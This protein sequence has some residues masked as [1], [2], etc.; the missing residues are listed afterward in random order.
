MKSMNETILNVLR[1]IT[2]YSEIEE[3]EHVLSDDSVEEKTPTKVI[4]VVNG[5]K[6]KKLKCDPGYKLGPTWKMCIKQDPI[7]L[8][9]RIK[10]AKN[11]AKTRGPSSKA[12]ALKRSKTM[13][14]RSSLG[15]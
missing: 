12:A 15:L 10:A 8:K 1:G 3:L 7:E 6:V 2:E 11:A 13:K 9:N 5:K 4:K 14:K